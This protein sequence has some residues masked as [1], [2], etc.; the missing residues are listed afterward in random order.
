MARER[1][2]TRTINAIEVSAICMDINTMENTIEVLSLTGEVPTDEQLLKK[3]RKLYE[4][5]T[6]KV[7]A[8]KNIKTTE[9]LFGMPEVEFLKY[10]KE[11]DPDTRKPL[12]ND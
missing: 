6:Y 9:K 12:S 10:A 4:T 8:I 5:D 11:L 7:V 2:V 1:A 3:L